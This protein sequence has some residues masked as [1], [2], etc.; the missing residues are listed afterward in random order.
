MV[1]NMFTVQVHSDKNS[2]FIFRKGTRLTFIIHWFSSV[3]AG[4]KL[5]PQKETILEDRLPVLSEGL[6]VSF[7]RG[8]TPENSEFARA[9]REWAPKISHSPAN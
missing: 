7:R 9:G 6:A 1:K 8:Y 3:L 2:L 5:Y 4:P